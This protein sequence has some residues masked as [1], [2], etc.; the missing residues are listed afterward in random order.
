[1]EPVRCD[2]KAP[3]VGV[4]GGDGINHLMAGICCFIDKD[5]VHPAQG[6]LLSF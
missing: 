2:R 4:G 3:A 1:M 6:V 5:S